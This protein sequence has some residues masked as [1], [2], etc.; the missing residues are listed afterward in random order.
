[1]PRVPLRETRT[2]A[3]LD[4]AVSPAMMRGIRKAMNTG[5]APAMAGANPGATAMLP[6]ASILSGCA[7]VP[8]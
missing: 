1:M 2:T 4:N 3:P 6:T 8:R 5:P 7:L